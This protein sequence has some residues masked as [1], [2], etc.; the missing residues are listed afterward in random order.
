[1]KALFAAMMVILLGTPAFAAPVRPAVKDDA[2]LFSPAAVEQADRRIEDVREQYGI[3]LYVETMEELPGAD[4]SRLLKMKSR[5]RSRFLRETAQQRAE[6]AGVDGIYL[7]VTTNP[8]NTVL[9]GWPE[10]RESEDLPLEKGGGLS[11][12][13]R[14]HELRRPFAKRLTS[15]PDGNLKA[16]IDH[17]RKAV[18]SRETPPPS[19]LETVPATILVAGMVGGWI[20]LSLL[21]RATARR[22]A[23][24]GGEQ[25]H[26]L[27][28]PGMLGSMFGVPA[29]FW[30]YDRLFRVERPP[31]PATV[32]VVEAPLPPVSPEP[33][34]AEE[35]VAHVESTDGPG[36]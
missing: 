35:P 22:Q 11:T 20:L 19:P 3:D 5:D 2:R 8:S 34:P 29:G 21:R 7:L 9:V 4:A 24:V 25:V 16:L 26:P 12:W 31:V 1:M 13:K 33:H 15:D 23:A 6:A 27:Y 28:H 14:E 10:R 17:F 32:A 18:H 30:V 36:I